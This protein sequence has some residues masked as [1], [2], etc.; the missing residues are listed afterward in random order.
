L[1]DLRSGGVVEEL[2]T[3]PVFRSPSVQLRINPFGNVT[4]LSTHEQILSGDSGQIFTG[5]QFPA[6]PSYAPAIARYADAVGRQFAKR[7]AVGSLCVDFAVAGDGEALWEPFALEV[8]LRNGGTTHPIT[9]LRHLVPGSYNV[10]TGR[11]V[12]TDGTPRCYRATDNM[13]D[14][15]W[16]GLPPAAVIT[17][18]A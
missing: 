15:A 14:I 1:S 12:T 11:W 10:E 2:I 8:N 13:V 17:A 4:V 9:V 18:V 5:C 7:G 3:A 16:L 6:D